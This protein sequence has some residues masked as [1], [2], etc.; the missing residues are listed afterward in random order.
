M[1]ASK[2]LFNAATLGLWRRRLRFLRRRP[3]AGGAGGA[4]LAPLAAAALVLRRRGISIHTRP[5]GGR[6]TGRRYRDRYRHNHNPA[7][8]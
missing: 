6:D 7:N 8:E 5:P 4:A 3:C 1:R 2:K